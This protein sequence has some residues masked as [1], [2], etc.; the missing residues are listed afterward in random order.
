[1]K[2]L[3]ALLACALEDLR[4]LECSFALVG[5][6]AVG[7]RAYERLTKDVDFSVL[8][9]SDAQSE[10]IVR[11]LQERHYQVANVMVKS[12]TKELAT[13]RFMMPGSSGPEPELDLLFRHV[14]IEDQIVAAS[15]KERLGDLELPVASR[16]H[17]IAMKTLS[18]R[19]ERSRDYDDLHQLMASASENEL[20][21][22][23]HA[24]GLIE[25][26]GFSQGADLAAKF[27][28]FLSKYSSH[29]IA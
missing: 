18:A 24:V 10:G 15:T 4:E 9:D 28:A 16:A 1:V 25:K 23:Q 27:K 29:P 21:E 3:E 19:K 8:S 7:F 17:L 5:G 2:N 26:R 6:I 20:R 13:V 22:A 14:G 12:S 11:S